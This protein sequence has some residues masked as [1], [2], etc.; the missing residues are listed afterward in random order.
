MNIKPVVSGLS[1]AMLLF[2]GSAGADV[3][4]WLERLASAYGGLDRITAVGEFQQHGVTYSNMRGK[5]GRVVRSYR[6]P[7]HL[8]IAI[9]YGDSDSEL[10]LLAGSQSWKQDQPGG[11]PFYSAMI[12]QASRLG[13]PAVLFAHQKSV[14][15]GGEYADSQGNRLQILELPFH[16]HNRLVVGIDIETGRILESA[17]NITM[18]GFN[19]QFGTRYA[20]FREVG[21]RLFAF[22]ETHYAMGRET[23]STRLQKIELA[24]LPDELFYPDETAPKKQGDDL[25]TR[26]E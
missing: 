18:Q 19:M 22:S 1:L 15:E 9:D 16:G 3:A 26:L 14:V 13:L 10:R 8:R 21:G 23:G 6:Y 5:E 4:G 25:L 11:Q 24:P 20:D 12:L 7:D 2:G 17:S